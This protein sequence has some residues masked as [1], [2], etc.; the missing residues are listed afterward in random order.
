MIKVFKY[1]LRFF[2]ILGV[3]SM[4][5][6]CSFNEFE[7]SNRI[8]DISN[9]IDLLLL[10]DLKDNSKLKWF[11]STTDSRYC[12]SAFIET[13]LISD[14]EQQNLLIKGI[15]SPSNCVDQSSQLISIESFAALDKY[16]VDLEFAEN[17]SSIISIEKHNNT[18]SINHDE[19]DYFSFQQTQLKITDKTL[20]WM[21]IEDINESSFSDIQE[22][23]QESFHSLQL[24]NLENG[25]YGYINLDDEIE[26]VL[27]PESLQRYT[28]GIAFHVSPEIDYEDLKFKMANFSSNLREM[29]PS[30]D[31]FLSTS[32]GD[33]F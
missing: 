12:E 18:Y 8:I 19:V 27:N 26:Y 13:Q 14:N 30:L 5:H 4:I 22:L 32:K 7:N 23:F 33:T 21:G 10:P 15:I 2:C 29:L 9:E 3:I 25:D 1:T 31:F 6:S 20:I 24:Y 16:N 17:L 28:M 11:V